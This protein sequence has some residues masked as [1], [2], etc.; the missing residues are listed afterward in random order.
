MNTTRLHRYVLVAALALPVAG[1]QMNHGGMAGMSESKSLAALEKLSGRAFDVAFMSQMIGHHQGAVDMA[2]MEVKNGKRADVKAA[3][4]AVIDAQK[5]EIAQLTAWLK[6]WYATAPD[7]AQVDLMKTDMKPMMDKAMSGMTPMAGHAM[8]ADRAFLEGMIPHHQDAIDMSKIALK[9]AA[10]PELRRFAQLVI[11]DQ[12]RE[13][14][15]YQAW[16]KAGY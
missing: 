8:N 13:I 12:S 4:Q 1:A 16:L 14:K 11:D 2:A 5:K 7:K 6:T 3:A 10:R 15:Q 9:K